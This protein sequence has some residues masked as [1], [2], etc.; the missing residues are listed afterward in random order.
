MQPMVT[1]SGDQAT[2]LA[3]VFFPAIREYVDAHRE[4]YELFLKEWEKAHQ[5]VS[6]Q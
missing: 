6:T 3:A 5:E 1:L 2:A 4:E